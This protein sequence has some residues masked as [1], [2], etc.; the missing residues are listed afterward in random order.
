MKKLLVRAFLFD[1]FAYNVCLASTCLE[2]TQF[3]TR[4]SL[5]KIVNLM[6]MI[7]FLVG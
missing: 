1:K 4:R 6:Y 5:T 2:S 7:Y 3:I